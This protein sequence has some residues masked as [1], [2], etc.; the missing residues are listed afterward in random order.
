MTPQEQR[1]FREI[2][3]RWLGGQRVDGLAFLHNSTVEA[4]LPSG[5]RKIGWLV[6]AW[7]EGGVT[8]YTVEAEDGS[9]D[10][11]CREELIRS[12]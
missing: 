12:V 2:N 6:S 1:A 3:K 9:G 5:E 11:D 4:T 8:M 7:F 10:Y